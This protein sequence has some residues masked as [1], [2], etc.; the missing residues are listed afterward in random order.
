M[1]ATGIL[2]RTLPDVLEPMH[3]AR[4]R[5]L[6]QAVEALIGGR[7]LTLT[8]MA[9]AW[10]GAI[11]MHAPLKALDRLL[12]NRHVHA[13]IVPLHQ[14]MARWLLRGKHPVILVD[15]SDLKRDGAWVLLRAAVPVGGRA[16]TLYEH[17]YPARQVNSPNAQETFLKALAQ[18]VPSG[19][20]PVLVTDAGF[21]SDWFRTVDSLGWHYIG[22]IRN[23]TRVRQAGSSRWRPCSD[24]F[25]EATGKPQD[26]GD[27]FIVKGDPWACRLVRIRR[28]CKRRHQ[29]TRKGTPTQGTV[30]RKARKSAHEPWLLA[31]SL[32]T[33]A[34]PAKAV[35]DMYAKRMQIE[36]AFRALK[37]HQYGMGFEDS[38]TRRA[39]RLAVLL[40]LHTLA[41]FAAW[42]LASRLTDTPADPDP[43]ARQASHRNR[44][45]LLR[46][47]EEWLR[48]PRLPPG[49]SLSLPTLVA[50]HA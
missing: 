9:R 4:R 24:L 42:L 14:A 34:F 17:I 13:A 33:R 10:P 8:G 31:T 44:Y 38:L 21:R 26:L 7:R 45:S 18:V 3:A 47:A 2:R 32:P 25:E 29:R 6:L 50:L 19:I 43:L 41:A 35:V 48:R 28:A 5:V 40:L 27:Y 20:Q 11:W 1:H 37:S 49:M 36:E 30:A 15:W 16:L 23:N 39:Q 12:S 22:R 46:R